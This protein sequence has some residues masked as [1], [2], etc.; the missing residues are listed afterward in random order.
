MTKLLFFLPLAALL[1]AAS[2]RA[3]GED[4]L[5]TP[6]PPEAAAAAQSDGRVDVGDHGNF[7]NGIMFVGF[8]PQDHPNGG[9]GTPKYDAYYYLINHRVDPNDKTWAPAVAA[10]LN[11][12]YPCKYWAQ[13]GETLIYEDEYIHTAPPGHGAPGGAIPGAKGEFIWGGMNGFVPKGNPCGG[14]SGQ[15]GPGGGAT[16]GTTNSTTPPDD[17]ASTLPSGGLAKGPGPDLKKCA[18]LNNPP[19]EGEWPITTRITK[20]EIRPNG[21]HVEFS[22]R[23]GPGRWPDVTPPGWKGPLQYTL[24]MVE[25]FGGDKWV[26]SAPIQFWYGLDESGGPPWE[27]RK[28]WFYDASRWG[29]LAA[30]QPAPGE[31]VGFFVIAGNV[32]NL[33]DEGSQSPVHERSNV[34][35]VPMPGSKGA[36]YNFK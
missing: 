34:V 27:F 13:D 20:L 21:V 11:K 9:A 7:V 18:I 26:A 10:A 17:S 4:D 24:G 32:R 29:P 30:R 19:S 36:T 5:V 35:Y 2:V 28:N 16:G 3:E 1:A 8:S 33:V 22:K 31:T 12:K 25:N 15:V 6:T 23:D 14:P